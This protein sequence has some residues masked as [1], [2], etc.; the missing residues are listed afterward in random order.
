MYS[1]SIKCSAAVLPAQLW[2][3][4]TCPSGKAEIDPLKPLKDTADT[5]VGR[6][7]YVGEDTHH[8]KIGSNRCCALGDRV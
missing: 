7:G 1:L 4:V 6:M 5:T 8:A 3:R 2:G